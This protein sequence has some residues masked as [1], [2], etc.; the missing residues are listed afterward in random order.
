MQSLFYR[1]ALPKMGLNRNTPKA[2]LY[3]PMELGGLELHDMYTEQLIQHTIKIQQH[4]RQ[5]DNIGKAFLS[6]LIAYEIVIGSSKNLFHIN[7]W[8]Y[9]YGEQASTV[10]YIWR[11]SRQWKLNL[12][13]PHQHPAPQQ[14]P[15]EYHTIMDEAASDPIYNK[16]DISLK[17][18][19]ACRL[20]HGL[21]YPSEMLLYNSKTF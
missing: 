19:N 11:M 5:N 12:D 3:G 6:N 17:A 20:Y 7:P 16:D 1:F 9:C 2:L 21:T 14:Y 10:Y 13:I 15:N 18:I 8:R 4:I